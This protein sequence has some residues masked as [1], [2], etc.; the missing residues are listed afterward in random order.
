MLACR[1]ELFQ[2]QQLGIEIA[3]TMCKVVGGAHTAEKRETTDHE[4]LSKDGHSTHGKNIVDAYGTQEGALSCHIGSSHYVE[5]RVA[6]AEIVWHSLVAKERMVYSFC[7]IHHLVALN[8][9]GSF[10]IWLVIAECGHRHESVEMT[11]SF[12]P[13]VNL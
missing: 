7:L 12:Y 9:L 3:Y 8:Y 13:I 11:H 5:M 10:G 4:T 2:S 6:D 1:D